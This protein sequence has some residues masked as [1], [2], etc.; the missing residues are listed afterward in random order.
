[1]KYVVSIIGAKRAGKST[2]AKIIED[3]V[4]NSFE[5]ALADKL[6]VELSLAYDLDIIHFYSQD[7]KELPFIYPLKTTLDKLC[8]MIESFAP[9]DSEPPKNISYYALLELASIEMK[10]PRDLMQHWGMFLRSIYGANVHCDHLELPSNFTIVSDVRFVNEFNYIDKLEGVV[11][12]PIYIE[13]KDA[14]AKADL[15]GHISEKE[16]KKL[17]KKCIRI[18]NNEKNLYNLSKSLHD[19]LGSI[20]ND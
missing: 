14:E 11:H 1:M 7:L 18:D 3:I 8:H 17:K 5:V 20:L 19:L 13:N 9:E 16:Y 10:T 4:D 15:D 6:K 12:I 2:A